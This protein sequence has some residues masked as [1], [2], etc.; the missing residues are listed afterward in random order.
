MIN[1]GRRSILKDFI[2]RKNFTKKEIKKIILKSVLHNLHTNKKIRSFC[3]YK[4]S[5]IKRFE[6]ISKQNSNICIKTGRYKGLLKNTH[7]SRHFVKKLGT[8]G[9]LQNFKIASW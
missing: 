1:Q 8:I 7:M 5:K 9:S 4:Y 2:F 6:S 3:L